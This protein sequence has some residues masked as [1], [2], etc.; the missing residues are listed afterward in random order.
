MDTVLPILEESTINFA[1]DSARLVWEGHDATFYTATDADNPDYTCLI[2]VTPDG[3][4]NIGGCSTDTSIA[5]SIGDHFYAYGTKP[6]FDDAEWKEVA[7]DF[8]LRDA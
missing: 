1:A 8:W 6:N 7:S 3:E 4:D 5:I 2:P